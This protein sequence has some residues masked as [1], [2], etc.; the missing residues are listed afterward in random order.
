MN[1][2]VHLEY[3]NDGAKDDLQKVL[4]LP[5]IQGYKPTRVHVPSV[6]WDDKFEIIFGCK[7][8]CIHDSY[9]KL[10]CCIIDHITSQIEV[11]G[12]FVYAHDKVIDDGD[13][14][15]MEFE[16]R[17]VEDIPRFLDE[18]VLKIPCSLYEIELNLGLK[19]NSTFSVGKD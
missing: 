17:N 16:L 12:N 11:H 13:D 5:T 2:P 15:H 1:D 18:L 9:Y 19:P 4:D 3:L 6:I 8:V 14:I 10:Y 7:N